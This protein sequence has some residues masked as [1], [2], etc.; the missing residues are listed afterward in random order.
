[1]IHRSSLIKKG[2][3]EEI[4]KYFNEARKNVKKNLNVLSFFIYSIE[5]PDSDLYRLAQIVD[6]ENTLAN[7]ID[8]F[9]GRTIS[10]PDNENFRNCLLLIISFYLIEF[11]NY[12]WADVKN[13]IKFPET[14]S[15]MFNSVSLGKK[16]SKIKKKS[17]KELKQ[18]IANMD[19]DKIE[20]IVDEK[21]L[22]VTDD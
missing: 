1:M 21:H 3:K 4:D 17:T 19:I 16:M 20:N 10:I 22:G 7:I 18:M 12:S 15:D 5:S 2:I 11:E 14:D 8:Y 9:G 13:L 6:D